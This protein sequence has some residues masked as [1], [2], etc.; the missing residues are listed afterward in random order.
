MRRRERV[1]GRR[2]LLT[3]AVIGGWSALMIWAARAGG[4]GAALAAGVLFTVPLSSLGE[5]VVHGILYHRRI[6]GLG[7]IRAIHHSGHHSA[8]FPPRHYVWHGPYEF[9]RVRRPY[10][11]FQMADNAVDN[12][13][14][15]WSQVALHFIVGLPLIVWPAWRLTGDAVFLGS[16]LAALAVISWLLAY[17]HGAIHTPKDRWIERRWWFQWLNRHHYI[18]HIDTTANINFG[19]PLCDFLLGTQKSELTAEEATTHP[20]FEEATALGPRYA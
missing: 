17:V 19:L 14:T 20:S 16:T 2:W 10:V 7:F 11:P 5:W 9:M 8:L 3:L 13:I 6:P 12:A 18:H 1:S 4:W 15:M